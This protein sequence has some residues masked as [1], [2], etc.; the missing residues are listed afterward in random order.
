MTRLLFVVTLGG[1]LGTAPPLDPAPAQPV[2]EQIEALVTAGRHPNLRWPVLSDV[3]A[4]LA[5]IYAGREWQ[6][7]WF[8]DDTLTAAARAL[9]RVL[10]QAQNRG[11]DPSDYD[12]GWFQAEAGRPLLSGDSTRVARLDVGL[13]VA[14]TRFAVALRLGRV[15]PATVH[16]TFKL[17]VDTFTVDSTIVGLAATTRPNDILTSLEPTL[18]HYYLLL[19]ALVRYRELAR[20]SELVRLPPMPRRLRPGESYAGLPTLRR[21]LR[22]LGDD[23]DSLSPPIVDT[24]YDGTIVDAVKHFQARQGFT[25]DG[26]IGDSTR[27][28]MQHPFDQPIRQMELTL[29]RFRW[30]PRH[31]S[32]PPIIVNIPAFR[33]Y[34]FRGDQS[35]ESS[36]L[37]MNV[38]VGTAFKTETPVFAANMTYL[39][40]APYWDVTPTIARKEVKPAATR[41]PAWLERNHMELLRRQEVVPATPE[42]IAAI[43]SGVRVRQTPGPHNALGGVKFLLPNDYQVYLHDTPVRSLFEKSRRDASHGCIRLEDAF[44]LAR[45]VLRDQPAWTDDRIREAMKGETP[46]RVDLTHPI[47][48]FV[49]YGTAIARENGDVYLYSD[50]YGHDRV[51]NRVLRKGYPYPK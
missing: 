4:D 30:M 35:D 19:G 3:Q 26:V 11:L 10:G 20:D 7:L 49:V 45:F 22:L 17:P 38:V 50:I 28:R 24:V 31:F 43:G 40:F 12:A 37:R 41:N 14:A 34:A 44:A 2:G 8:A 39:I 46:L 21:L 23:R 27:G 15:N 33:L 1:A 42:N 51:L 16:A 25:P 29:E 13:S 48:V 32:A 6:P 18:L 47:P 5:R 36:L 9:I